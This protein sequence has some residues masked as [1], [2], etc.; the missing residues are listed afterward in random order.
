M[1]RSP[2]AELVSELFETFT[3]GDIRRI[4]DM[5][6]EGLIIRCESCG[7]LDTPDCDTEVC[8]LGDYHEICR[9]CAEKLN[10]EFFN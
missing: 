6:E 9:S 1:E 2:N 10:T 3:P 5:H 7:E 4:L 8:L